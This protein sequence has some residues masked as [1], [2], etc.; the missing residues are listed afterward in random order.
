MINKLV[1]V[2]LSAVVLCL[3]ACQNSN[4]PAA[5]RRV[6]SMQMQVDSAE[7]IFLSW[8]LDSLSKANKAIKG[9]VTQVSALI[10]ENNLEI[11][12]EESIMM[13]DFKAAAKAFKGMNSTV[14]RILEEIEYTR[15]QLRVLKDDLNRKALSADKTREYV[16]AEQ[17]AVDKL[18]E[19]VSKMQNNFNLSAQRVAALGPD[20]DSLISRLQS[21]QA[22]Q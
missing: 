4:D 12:T 9:R 19:T 6:D 17:M 10:E 18:G 7:M 1:I 3:T 11:S 13:A 15:N 2:S 22:A 21:Q 20:V 8:N 5:V 16:S 14:P